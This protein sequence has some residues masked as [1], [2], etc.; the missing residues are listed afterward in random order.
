MLLFYHP[1]SLPRP[2]PLQRW[3]VLR[4]LLQRSV[5]L[6]MSNVSA[7]CEASTMLCPGYGSQNT[8]VWTCALPVW[9]CGHGSVATRPAAVV[10]KIQ[11]T[12]ADEALLRWTKLSLLYS[13]AGEEM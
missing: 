9:L 3:G 13:A 4:S 7:A 1:P 10:C 11:P 6:F 5:P 2:P 12:Q 8:A